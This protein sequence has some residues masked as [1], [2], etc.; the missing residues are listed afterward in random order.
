LQE[1]S[2]HP[3]QGKALSQ[4]AWELM[5]ERV[6]AL[7]DALPSDKKVTPEELLAAA[8]C[9]RYAAA[10]GPDGWSGG[11]LRRLA[12]LFPT[13]VTEILWTEY[14]ILLRGYDPLLV[15]SVTDSIIVGLPKPT[16]GNRPI[17][18]SRITARCVLARVVKRSRAEVEGYL[19]RRNQFAASGVMPA[20]A[21]IVKMMFKCAVDG[22]P[23]VCTD[24][25]FINAFNAVAQSAMAEGAMK[26][27]NFAS[28]MAACT[29]RT[30]CMVREPGAVES[31]IRGFYPEG[32]K[33]LS[34]SRHARGTDQG[35]PVSSSGF[36]MVVVDI[37]DQ[38]ER[39]MTAVRS[40]MTSEE[41]RTELWNAMR[42]VRPELPEEQPPRVVGDCGGDNERAET[43]SMGWN[44]RRSN[45]HVLG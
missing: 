30:Q 41:A 17:V 40:D 8:R 13:E 15:T 1:K 26:M 7:V 16:G 43:R 19:R 2:P 12:T 11:F 42:R 24:D 10:P 25:D 21:V 23:F 45:Q 31:M 39:C 33:R 29:L 5:A 27:S 38:A 35:S 4:E 18:I 44:A 36:A 37:N 6:D 28:E 22:V 32:S 14:K 9:Q 20:I 3:L 34:V